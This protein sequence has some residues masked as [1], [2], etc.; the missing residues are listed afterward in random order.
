MLAKPKNILNNADFGSMFELSQLR[1]FVAVSEYLHFGQ[2]AARLNMTQPPLSRQIQL[3]E[4]NIGAVLL[5]RSSRSVRL[6]PAGRVFL[7]EARRILRLAESA[8]RRAQR[9]SR[10]EA[11]TLQIGFT[12]ASGYQMM[13]DL[14]ARLR[15]PLKGV[16]IVLREMVTS[17]QVEA[18]GS[19]MLDVGFVRP[20]VDLQRFATR[21]HLSE[22][23]LA[24]IPTH[25]PLAHQDHLSL[26]DLH[27]RP[28]I[29]YSPDAASYFHDLL[30]TIFTQTQIMPQIVL[31]VGQMHS[32]LGLV[33]AGFGF[34][35]VPEAAACL[36]FPGLAFRPMPE[37]ANWTIKLN[38][39]WR[40]DN[41]NPALAR[42]LQ[43]H[44][45]A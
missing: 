36:Q 22:R 27:E 25:D 9:V 39:V 13:P 45:A 43:A 41:E 31:E 10:G 35:L 7:P 11:G 21:E 29:M 4:R 8:T 12:A 20:Q 2:A 3:L 19:G 6:T 30:G 40:P 24:A 16:D 14:M 23:L 28:F 37:L 5:E 38:M 44:A 17:A 18:L 1:C 15:A 34:A 33:N 32:M 42:M 26:S